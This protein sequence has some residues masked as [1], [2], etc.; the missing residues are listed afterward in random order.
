M[1]QHR[2]YEVEITRNVTATQLF[3]PERDAAEDDRNLGCNREYYDLRDC[4]WSEAREV[5]IAEEIL[6]ARIENAA[7]PDEEYEIIEEEGA[8][9]PDDIFGLDIGVAS[10]VVALSAAGCIPFS[11]CNAGAFGGL[12]HEWHPVVAFYARP[13]M[14]DL[15]L[16]CAQ[17][18]GTGL[19]SNETGELIIYAD[20]IRLMRAFAAA[21]MSRQVAFQGLRRS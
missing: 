12:H 4:S 6:I 5:Y 21:L 10:T 8:E 17:E 15:L 20:D 3:W 13:N 7:D 1:H 11:S 19:E 16:E 2:K 14:V 9:E 18:A